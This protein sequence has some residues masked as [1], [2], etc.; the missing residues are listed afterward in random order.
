[1]IV[2]ASSENIVMTELE[3]EEITETELEK[4][5]NFAQDQINQIINFFQQIANSLGIQ[6]KLSSVSEKSIDEYWEK[7]IKQEIE[8][9]WLTTSD[10]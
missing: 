1:L 8:K 6:K 2:T 3:A 5:V 4:A 7:K 9:I 10:N